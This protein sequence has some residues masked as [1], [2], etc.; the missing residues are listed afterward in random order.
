MS[1]LH[2]LPPNPTLPPVAHQAVP[3]P[4]PVG[5]SVEPPTPASL[6]GDASVQPTKI[7][8]GGLPETTRSEDLEDCFSQIG[9]LVKVDLKGAYGF[10]VRI[11]P[12]LL[13]SPS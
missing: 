8:I 1:E 3:P 10:V 2:S 4:P 12:V 9:R 5:S 7:Y 13:A 11:N 6:N